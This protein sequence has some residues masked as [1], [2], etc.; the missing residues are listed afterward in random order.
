MRKIIYFFLI[1]L[2]LILSN[3]I[4]AA[5]GDTTYLKVFNTVSFNHY[6]NFDQWGVFPSSTKKFQR[7]MMKYTV[8]CESNGQC[9]WDYT[10][11]I[12]VRNNTHTKD[13]TLQKATSFTING[14][15]KDSF[16]Y[17][18]DTTW[19]TMYNSTTHTTDS[20]KSTPLVLIHFQ[21]VNALE[22][23]VPIDTLVVWPVQYYNYSYD[24]SGTKVDSTFVPV[25]HTVR[26]IYINYYLVFDKIIDYE[27]GRMI[28]PYAKY[29]TL[30][31]PFA[32]EYLYDVTDYA[33]MLH[34]SV[35]IRMSYSGYT[36]GFTGTIEFFMI[37][38]TPAREAY[39]VENLWNGY[40][41][42]GNVTDPI[43]NHLPS[44]LFTKSDSTG[45]IKLRMTITGHGFDS[46][47]CCE[48][49][50]NNY[51]L[52]LN[53][54]QI[55]QNQIWKDCGSIPIINQGGT[56]IY[57]RA[58]W[59]PG[60]IVTPY[61]Y[62]LNAPNGIDSIDVNMDTYFSNG[63]GG[64]DYGTQLIYYKPNTYITDAGIETILSPSTDFIFN[65]SN[66]ICENAKI[67]IRNFGLQ[68][69]TSATIKYQIGDGTPQTY[70]WTGIL[71]FDE[72]A[73]VTLP[74]IN[75]I[76]PS[77]VK[78]FTVWIDQANQQTDENPFN[79]LKTS[80]FQLPQVLPFSF[81]V[82]THTNS[83]PLENS[84]TIKASWGATLFYKTFHDSNTVIRDT[85]RLGYGCYTFNF[86][87]SAGDGL[88]FWNNPDQ[89]TGSVRL[90]KNPISSGTSVIKTF[91]PDF[92]NFINFNF[93]TVSQVDVVEVKNISSDISIY[94]Q[95]ANDKVIIQI[96]Q[97]YVSKVQLISMDG[98]VVRTFNENEIARSELDISTI[99][100]GMYILDFATPNGEH[101]VKKLV[102][103][104]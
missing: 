44:T 82:E 91:N 78:T 95:P 27:M 49:M 25:Q 53:G 41:G 54:V 56:W 47:G 34:D 50:P 30:P 32:Y 20:V 100:S 102:V 48:F 23:Q 80:T 83:R 66:P 7:I 74:S 46:N 11:T 8:S 84:Y 75:W 42:F 6:G 10:N 52:K 76:D 68:T 28:T 70:T 13:S 94:P 22:P 45:S 15:V 73:E 79:N 69:L 2:L 18:T 31:R 97:I 40:Y 33:S 57:N 86:V 62:N 88:S 72:T 35:E 87:D 43:D 98:R 9:E 58:N 51:Y 93:R 55:A 60:T 63:G 37:E 17:S 64:Y 89:G 85:F 36:W 92:G 14:A 65:R 21:F 1:S 29:G 19:I 16:S 81:I 90:M 39:K 5:N 67:V 4:Q 61:E 3:S 24:T 77:G 104:K 59:C 103:V 12:Y 96:D 26:A 38:G 71:K 101:A 99:P